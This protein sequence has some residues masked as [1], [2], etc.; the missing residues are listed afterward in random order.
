MTWLL[1]GFTD[2]LLLVTSLSILEARSHLC[3]S[4]DFSGAD[5]VKA[6]WLF[7]NR[8]RDSL[9][10]QTMVGGSIKS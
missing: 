1:A 3:K 9:L 2:L 4:Q 5:G 8:S 7:R 6:P 10:R